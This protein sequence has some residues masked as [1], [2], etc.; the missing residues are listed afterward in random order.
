MPANKYHVLF[1]MLEE[2]TKWAHL[3]KTLA[4]AN[5]VRVE[6]DEIINSS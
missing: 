3:G 6:C 5:H 4:A 1:N 2:E